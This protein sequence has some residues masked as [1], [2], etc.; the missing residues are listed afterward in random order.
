MLYPYRPLRSVDGEPEIVVLEVDKDEKFVEGATPKSIKGE[1]IIEIGGGANSLCAK[2]AQWLK[3]NMGKYF[4][5]TEV[6]SGSSDGQVD[7]AHAM[8]KMLGILEFDKLREN[9]E[10]CNRKLAD[11]F[12]GDNDNLLGV[13]K[14]RIEWLKITKESMDLKKNPHETE[15]HETEKQQTAVFPE[16]TAHD[17]WF[18]RQLLKAVEITKTASEF[19][20]KKPGERQDASSTSDLIELLTQHEE[21][22]LKHIYDEVNWTNAKQANAYQFLDDP[23]HKPDDARKIRMPVHVPH[24]YSYTFLGLVTETPQ[25]VHRKPGEAALARRHNRRMRQ[26]DDGRGEEPAQGRQPQ[27]AG[28]GGRAA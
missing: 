14:G 10:T 7:P 27:N 8:G 1:H 25:A 23:Y 24:I 20:K 6:D 26:G 15:P 11:V 13:R 3:D 2:V 17:K 16:F 28:R 19:A 21:A 5:G 12:A 18:N 4:N 9:F 22:I